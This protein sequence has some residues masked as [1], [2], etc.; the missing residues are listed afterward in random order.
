MVRWKVGVQEADF[1]GPT[2]D[3]WRFR[4]LAAQVFLGCEPWRSHTPGSE[5]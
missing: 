2:V 5:V 4:L 1:K 3:L